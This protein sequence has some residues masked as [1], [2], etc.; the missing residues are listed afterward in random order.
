MSDSRW[1]SFA[2][3]ILIIA[4]LVFLRV[5][6]GFA[7]QTV[8]NMVFDQFQR[9]S[10]RPNTPQPV[11]I[12]DIDEASLAAIGQFP[13]PRSEMARLVD[14]LNELGAGAIVFDMVFPEPDRLS[15]KTILNRKDMKNWVDSNMSR[16][17]ERNFPDND[18][19]FAKSIANAPVV[20]GFSIA[21]NTGKKRPSVKWGKVVRGMD[22]L[23]AL[24][25]FED[26][27]SN[28]D[29]IEK[30]ASGIGSINVTPRRNDDIIRKVPL[31][32]T[33]DGEVF[34]SLDMEALRVAQGQSTYIIQGAAHEPGIVQGVR[35]GAFDI[36]TTWN[37][38][39]WLHYRKDIPETYVPAYKVLN[40][41][42]KDI[43]RLKDLIEGHIVFVGTSAVGLHDIRTSPLGEQIPG[44]SLHAQIVEQILSGVRLWRPDYIEGVEI[45][46]VVVLGILIIIATSWFSPITSLSLGGI[47]T[48]III[49]GAWIAF[50]R[51]GLLVDPAYAVFAGLITHF[52][53]T[54]YHYLITDR[55]A[56][57]VRGA[58]AKFVSPEVLEEI[59]SDPEGLELGGNTR[60]LT[61]MFVDIRNFTPLSE[62]LSPGDL[63]KFLNRLLDELSTCIVEEKGTIDKYIGDSIMAFWNA[64]VRIEDHQACACRAA[65]RMRETLKRLNETDAFNFKR[66]GYPF[67]EIAIG[68]GINT[69]P[70]C[71]GNLGSKDRFDYSVIGDAVNVAARMESACKEVGYDIVIAGSTAEGIKNFAS[72]DAGK[73]SLKGKSEDQ[74]AYVLVG[75][76][77][78]AQTDE[79][80]ALRKC[81]DSLLA[82][83]D[84]AGD[85]CEKLARKVDAGLIS[86]LHKMC[87]NGFH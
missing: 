84:I 33:K 58:F 67:A 70:A 7:V 63:V 83:D 50:S 76:E 86:F 54:A 13:W 61:I 11:R 80:S 14:N 52:A 45:A 85:N 16:P 8:R 82:G 32:W 81:H 20:V 57:F 64:P 41:E 15:P 55:Q 56:R 46:L 68:T 59:S 5:G 51:Y 47:T 4:A 25:H 72:L 9:L 77:T 62:G 6:D 30:A 22:I 73:V 42:N 24:P 3:G 1:T 66:D 29:I 37:G 79:F 27:T 87:D 35:I 18:E 43:D 28:I 23:S 69:G 74:Q 21:D 48:L 38:E 49:T 2:F 60:Q 40:L 78:M 71:V 65:L 36:D 53:M 10:P 31:L 39:F 34:P 12:I 26:V 17:G 19:I 44:V 75:D